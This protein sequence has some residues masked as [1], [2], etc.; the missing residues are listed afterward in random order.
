MDEINAFLYT[1][2]TV[3]EP[4]IVAFQT[5]ESSIGHEYKCVARIAVASDWLNIERTRV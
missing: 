3:Y 1:D 2:L 5:R 4:S